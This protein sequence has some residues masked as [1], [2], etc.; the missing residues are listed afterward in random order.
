MSSYEL[1][2]FVFIHRLVTYRSSSVYRIQQ[3]T[4]L[5]SP[6]IPEDESR[7]TF[8]SVVIFSSFKFFV[9]L[10][11]KVTLSKVQKKTDAGDVHTRSSY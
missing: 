4:C 2:C 7:S 3:N 6:L 1:L 5:F 11:E 9:N 10:K 8:R